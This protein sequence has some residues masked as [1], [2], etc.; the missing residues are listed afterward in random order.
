MAAEG[1]PRLGE[2]AHDR[3]PAIDQIGSQPG[4]QVL[5]DRGTT[6]QQHVNVLPLRHTATV[7]PVRWQAVPVGDRHL[8]VCV[9]QYPRGEQAA[10]AGADDHCVLTDL[11]HLTPQ[12]RDAGV[13]LAFL[14]HMPRWRLRATPLPVVAY[15]EGYGQ[16]AGRR[17][18]GWW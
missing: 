16:Q 6:W 9:G 10:D 12:H 2:V 7:A 1:C 4:K 13:S 8:F 18:P 5:K 15:R 3:R 17:K 14:R 11:P